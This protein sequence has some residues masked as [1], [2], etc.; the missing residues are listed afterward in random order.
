[1]MPMNR[2][3]VVSIPLLI[4]FFAL[5]GLTTCLGAE[6]AVST[7]PS[8][9]PQPTLTSTI[10]WF[11]STATPTFAPTPSMQ[12]T[13]DMH[14]G[15]GEVILEDDFT[16]ENAWSTGQFPSGNATFGVKALTLAITAP[17][18][19]LSSLRTGTLL[20]DFYLEITANPLLCRG[21]DV[22]GVLFREIAGSSY[23]RLMLNCNGMLRLERVSYS[24]VLTLQKWQV[25]GQLAAGAPLTVRIGI[26]ARGSLLRIFINNIFQFE[27]TDTRFP[28]GGVGVFAI[29]KGAT[30]VTVS[31][32]A[33][34]VRAL[35]P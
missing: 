11:P 23:Y 20:T 14:P 34:Q 2:R 26:W 13:V 15:L 35:T 30:A 28:A 27:A 22:Y 24:D 6:S 8:L 9:T 21:E 19:Y 18:G 12:P 10:Q 3:L 31:F 29:S 1:M 32:S 16:T 25:S 5:P 4:L 33:L 17:S 7:V